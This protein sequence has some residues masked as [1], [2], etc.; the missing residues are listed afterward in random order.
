M[1]KKIQKETGR[2]LR[3]MIESGWIVF[4]QIVAVIGSL[5]LVKVLTERLT[6]TQYG[7]LALGLTVA[8][9]V[10]QVVMGGISSGMSR[11][12]SVAVEKNEQIGRA[13]V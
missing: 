12:Y 4:G 10:N 3:I 11:F 5:I 13:H 7:E 9:L 1:S 8:G 2:I 6:P